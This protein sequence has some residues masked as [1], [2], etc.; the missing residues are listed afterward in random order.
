LFQGRW[1]EVPLESIWEDI[2]RRYGEFSPQLRRAAQFVR[3]HPQDVALHSLRFVSRSAGVSPTSLTRLV[4]ALDLQSYEEFQARHRD[5]LKDGRRGAFSGRADRLISGARQPGAVDELLDAMAEAERANV[6]AALCH[7][8]RPA[9]QQAA[10]LVFAAPGVAV[11]GIR[12]CFPA[13]YSLHYTLSLFMPGVRILLGTGGSFLDDLH[14]LSDGDVLV[15]ISVAPYSREIVE[16]AKLA[17]AEGVRVVAIGDSALSPIARLADVSLVA[18]NDS[19]AHIASPI[20][21]IAAA[22]A[23]AMLILAR[24]GG[25]ALEALR[26]REAMLEATSAY[27]DEER[28]A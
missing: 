5:W 17:R 27:V 2:D 10:D 3:K 20:G 12:S 19:P 1:L 7:E 6:G 24:A 9:L 28:V 8:A 25:S 26:R 15:V 22:Q 18:T 14:Q 23:L 4:Q 13:A 16:A 11:A 21:L